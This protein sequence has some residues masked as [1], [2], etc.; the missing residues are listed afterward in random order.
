MILISSSELLAMNFMEIHQDHKFHKS[1]DLELDLNYT[2][3]GQRST[4]CFPVLASLI[5]SRKRSQEVKAL[6]VEPKKNDSIVPSAATAS[7]LLV[8]NA[9]DKKPVDVVDIE[10]LGKDLE[11]ASPLEIMDKALEKFRNDIAIAFR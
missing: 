3:L 2:L 10:K 1:L 9:V 11:N 4:R 6:N 8:Y 7:L 5:L